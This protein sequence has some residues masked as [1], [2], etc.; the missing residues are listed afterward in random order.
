MCIVPMGAMILLTKHGRWR[1]V[2]VIYKDMIGFLWLP[3]NIS[4]DEVLRRTSQEGNHQPTLFIQSVLQSIAIGKLINEKTQ[5]EQYFDKSR[6]YPWQ[7]ELHFY[8]VEYYLSTIKNSLCI[9]E[10][11]L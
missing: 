9:F 1:Y 3:T 2:Q 6:E 7:G 10:K 4:T 8:I 11:Y 5:Y